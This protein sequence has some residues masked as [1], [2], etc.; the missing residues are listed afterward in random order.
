MSF[1][2]AE[3]SVTQDTWTLQIQQIQIQIFED[4]CRLEFSF[5]SLA[6]LS[7]TRVVVTHVSVSQIND[8]LDN[9]LFI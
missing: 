3:F 4:K 1:Q 7:A 6:A 8:I 9:Y 5:L 2:P